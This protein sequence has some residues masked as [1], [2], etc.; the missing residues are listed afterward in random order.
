MLI[1]PEI[2]PVAFQLGPLTVHWYGL[3]YLFAFASVWGLLAYRIKYSPFPRGFTYQELS[4][5]LFYAAIGTIIGGRL[6]YMLF[7]AR[8]DLFAN[9]FL[10]FQIW[11]GGMSFHGGL[12]GVI[13]TL[14]CY[15]LYKKKYLGDIADFVIPAVPIGLGFGR[16]GNFINSELWG[17]RIKLISLFFISINHESQTNDD[18]WQGKQLS[19]S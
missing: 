12:I 19:L 3:M 8:E 15:G 14:S 16:I 13:V 2:N 5:L 6:G 11:K 4:D 17:R 1:Y 18:H 9:P 10:L 7:Y